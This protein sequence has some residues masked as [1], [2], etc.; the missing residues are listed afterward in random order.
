MAFPLNRRFGEKPYREFPKCV[1]CPDACMLK[2]G[3]D[4]FASKFQVKTPR[5]VG[6]GFAGNPGRRDDSCKSQVT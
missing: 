3:V 2:G 1:F 4:D 5:C 6:A